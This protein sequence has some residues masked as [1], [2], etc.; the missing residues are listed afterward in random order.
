[1]GKEPFPSVGKHHFR[2]FIEK[3]NWS[4]FSVGIVNQNRRNY[5]NSHESPDCITYFAKNGCIWEQEFCRGRGPMIPD[6]YL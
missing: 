1:M 3:I 5:P 4:I 2:V 6:I